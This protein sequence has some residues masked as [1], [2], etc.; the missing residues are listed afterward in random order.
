M[1]SIRLADIYHYHDS[2]IADSGG[3]DGIRDEGLIESAYN[4]TFQ[5]F[6]DIEFYETVEEKATRIGYGL[7]KNHGFVD[8][9]KR[10][11]C[12]VLLSFLQINGISLQCSTKELADIF[13]LVASNEKSY[14]DLLLFV[15]THMAGVT[16]SENRRW[17]QERRLHYRKIQKYGHRILNEI[18]HRI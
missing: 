5:G 16:V 18:F 3:D 14:D 15:R 1:K 12:L 11:G 8:G 9:N 4:A 10:V 7:A 6:G 13:Y 2:V 17:F